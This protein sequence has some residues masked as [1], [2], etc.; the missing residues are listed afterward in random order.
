MYTVPTAAILESSGMVAGATR[1]QFLIST[2]EVDGLLLIH[3]NVSGDVNDI[4]EF[5]RVT[6]ISPLQ[7][8]K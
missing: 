8:K 1:R 2:S 7:M 6:L 5:L 4:T 3:R